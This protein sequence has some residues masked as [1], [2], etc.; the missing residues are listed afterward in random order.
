MDMDFSLKEAIKIHSQ[1]HFDGILTFWEDDVL[2]TAK[3]NE[4]LNLK[5]IPYSQAKNIRNKYEFRKLC[6][7][8]GIRHPDFFHIDKT[9]TLED[10][11]EFPFPC[12]LKPCFGSS[13]AF[14][15]RCTSAE[16][17]LEKYKNIRGNFSLET[18]TALHN[19]EDFF[20]ESFLYGEEVDIDILVQD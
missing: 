14:V 1:E 4:A 8:L 6:E 11:K 9:T 20:I 18:E 13:S 2:L 10:L 15:T 5:G 16:E 19:G 7:S 12:V 17:V 3:I